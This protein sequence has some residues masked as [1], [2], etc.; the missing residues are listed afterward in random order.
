MANI[1]KEHISIVPEGAAALRV[2][3]VQIHDD[4]IDMGTELVCERAAAPW[5]AAELARAADAWGYAELDVVKGP[6]H[7]TVYIGGSDMQPFV[8]LHNQRD[9]AAP[10]GKVYALGMST[11]TAR[12]LAQQ[13][14]AI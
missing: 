14:G 13:L 8:H 6:D 5:L 4:G 2:Q 7:F 9:P 3:H 10:S 1:I 11:D 12:A